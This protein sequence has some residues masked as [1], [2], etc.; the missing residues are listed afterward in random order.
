MQNTD[1][2]PLTHRTGQTR[3]RGGS[4]VQPGR[5]AASSNNQI[6]N[7]IDVG[8]ALRTLREA[9]ALSIRA[10]AQQSGLAVNTLSLIENGKTSPSVSTLQQLANTLRV[11]ITAFFEQRPPEAPVILTRASERPRALFDQGM[12]EDLGGGLEDCPVE[13]FLV[14]LAAGASSGPEPITH[15]GHEFVLCLAGQIA[16]SV[17]NHDMVLARG[18]SLLFEAELPHRWHNADTTESQMVV[19]FCPTGHQHR[20]ERLHFIRHERE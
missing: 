8:S 10:L 6:D 13:P 16:Y 12:L 14:T 2:H 7:Q 3:Q 15:P 4:N 9:R 17:H 1:E 18:D 20:P 19:M 5:N 11:P